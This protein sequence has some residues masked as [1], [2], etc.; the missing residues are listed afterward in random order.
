MSSPSLSNYAT[1]S[2]HS[3][4][5]EMTIP[6]PEINSTQND[7]VVISIDF[8]TTFSTVSYLLIPSHTSVED[9]SV[10]SVT[11]ISGYPDCWDASSSLNFQVPTAVLYSLKPNDIYVFDEPDPELG[12]QNLGSD[13]IDPATFS[14][15]YSL[16]IFAETN[17]NN[18]SI[19][20]HNFKLL[21]D[22]NPSTAEIRRDLEGKIAYLQEH[23]IISSKW[24]VITHYLTALLRHTKKQLVLAQRDRPHKEIVLCVPAIWTQK[25]C[26]IM[27]TC[28]SAAMQASQLGGLTQNSVGDF[29]N[30][31]VYIDNFFLVS[32]PEAAAAKVLH[33][34]RY[35]LR[36]C[37]E[38]NPFPSFDIILKQDLHG[39]PITDTLRLRRETSLLS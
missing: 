14:W 9:V 10:D 13:P 38:Q 5:T 32:E 12:S 31:R 7:R 6:A 21:L 28:L 25:S 11:T 16:K 3:H 19:S 2:D 34:D 18:P 23:R 24:D 4:D 35:G 39:T 8:G 36:V 26:R 37:I 27:Q 29:K 22:D 15:G 20:L 30:S 17:K 1:C 33:Q